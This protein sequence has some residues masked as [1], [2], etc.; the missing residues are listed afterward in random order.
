MDVLWGKEAEKADTTHQSLKKESHK[1]PPPH[2]HTY[3]INRHIK[4][5]SLSL[6]SAHG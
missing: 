3:K 2:K 5:A 1:R 6:L 4:E